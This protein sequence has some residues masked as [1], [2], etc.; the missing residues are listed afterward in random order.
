MDE[1]TDLDAAAS[2]TDQMELHQAAGMGD[3]ARVLALVAA[4]A[5]VNAADHDGCTPLGRAV[6]RGATAAVLA[7]LEAGSN[8]EA[9]DRFGQT[10]L[11]HVAFTGHTAAV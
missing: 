8:V 10:A 5:D 2:T 11:H 9:T 1:A 3:T 7:L 6:S 4:G